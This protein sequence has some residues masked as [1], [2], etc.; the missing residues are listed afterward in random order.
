MKD[1]FINLFVLMLLTSILVQA[2]NQNYV[3]N[4]SK[5]GTQ[6]AQ[7]LKIPQGAR[8][9][10][11]GSAFTAVAD[12]PSS[13]FWNVAGIARQPQNTAMF[14][15]T[16]WFADVDYNAASTSFNIGGMGAVG[17][18]F[19]SSNYGDMKVTT[20]EDPEGTGEMFT[21]SDIAVSIGWAMN[22]SDNFSVGLNPK[23]ISQSI[24]K[25]NSTALA[26][27]FGVL[28]N[29]PFKGITLGMSITNFGQKM[30]LTGNSTVILVDQDIETVGNNDN[31]PAHLQTEK[32]D[33]PMGFKLGI[34]WDAINSEDHRLLFAAD[35]SHPS[36]DYESVNA[37]CEYVFQDVFSLRGG[38]K[39]MFLDYA[40][41]TFSVGAGLKQKFLRNV[42]VSLDYSY[43][44]FNRLGSI[45]KFAV[46]FNF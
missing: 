11:M 30:Q 46:S 22:I 6:A 2:Q 23:L 43:T 5:R 25:T 15:H 18:S 16:Q 24:W 33:L 7:F 41:E 21:A 31:I 45:Q 34:A 29:T 14:E 37:G 32:W 40:E 28:Y 27:D 4:V 42:N 17:V 39:N 9:T 13:I 8:A 36:D 3:E 19:I 26:I 35:A 38:Y 44:Y 20:I 1:R 10:S 12:D